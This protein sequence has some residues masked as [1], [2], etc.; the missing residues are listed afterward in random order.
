[1][2]RFNVPVKPSIGDFTA[3]RDVWLSVNDQTEG[4]CFAKRDA[5]STLVVAV[6]LNA[7]EIAS[8]SAD[9]REDTFAVFREFA[10]TQNDIALFHV[11]P[12]EK[13]ISA[14]QRLSI[15]VVVVSRGTG[16]VAV[17]G[18]TLLDYPFLM[19]DVLLGFTNLP[20]PE[21]LA[22][23]GKTV[24]ES[25]E[26]SFPLSCQLE[27]AL[28]NHCTKRF[29]APLFMIDH[30]PCA[31]Y[32][33]P[34]KSTLKTV[35]MTVDLFKN[36]ML[37]FNCTRM[38]QIE[39][40]IH[41]ALVNAITYGN[42]MDAEKSITVEYEVGPKGLRV[43]V[44][45]LGDGFDVSNI[46]VPVGEEALERISGRGIYMMRKFSDAMFYNFKGNELLLF[47]HF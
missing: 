20:S 31:S 39:T 23:I 15:A 17:V 29:R 33:F 9:T 38:W 7:G 44:K 18:D 46:S 19:D 47:F 2:K 40:V 25:D 41:E 21:E 28:S 11:I 1:M 26:I 43:I 37:Q 16:S 22:V 13:R 32:S 45:D 5:R 42:D 36:K 14:V 12:E 8:L 10:D 30:S 34:V 4:F 3:T 27:H 35:A 6:G 24:K